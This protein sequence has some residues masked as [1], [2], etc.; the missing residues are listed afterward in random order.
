LAS[1]TFLATP[2]RKESSAGLETAPKPRRQP[3][4]SRYKGG[5]LVRSSPTLLF[6]LYSSCVIAGLVTVSC[7]TSEMRATTMSSASEQR[8]G[9]VAAVVVVFQ[10]LGGRR[11]V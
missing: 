8:A 10:F 3:G 2:E 6:R 4:I 11:S 5:K 9:F 1:G 7:T